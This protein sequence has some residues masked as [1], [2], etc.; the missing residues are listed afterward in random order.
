MG[1]FTREVKVSTSKTITAKMKREKEDH[2]NDDTQSPKKHP[3]EKCRQ[4]DDRTISIIGTE[5]KTERGSDD[6]S[7]KKT[8]E[9]VIGGEVILVMITGARSADHAP[10]ATSRITH[11][12]YVVYVV[13]CCHFL[14]AVDVGCIDYIV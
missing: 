14:R 6:I 13:D 4:S 2:G 8:D 9:M 7:T 12:K 11:E 3:T 10:G 5:R 1:K